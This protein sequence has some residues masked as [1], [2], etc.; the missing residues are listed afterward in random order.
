[1]AGSDGSGASA[2]TGAA[3]TLLPFLLFFFFLSGLSG[4]DTASDSAFLF[5][6]EPDTDAKASFSLLRKRFSTSTSSI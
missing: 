3:L 2:V 1:M 5:F 6:E 4:D